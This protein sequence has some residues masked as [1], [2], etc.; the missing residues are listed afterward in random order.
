MKAAFL[1]FLIGLGAARAW[2]GP[3]FQTDDPEP[4]DYQHYEFYTFASSDGTPLET[5][6]T[7]PATEFNWGALPNI[8][9]HV[10]VPA[11]TIMPSDEP[12]EFG[13]GDIETG[14]KYRFVQETKHRPMI[15]TFTMF[16][17]PSGNADRGL[18]VGKLW[19]K[20]P[21][22]IQKSFGPWTTYGG[23]GETLIH[24]V[25]GY[26]NFPFA[27]WLIQRDLGKKWTLG[28]EAFYH[29][30]EGDATPQ[31]RSST[32]V[33]FGGYY[34]F[35]DPGFQLLFA[36]GHNVAGQTENYAYFGL[37]WTWGKEKSGSNQSAFAS[38]GF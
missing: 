27:G 18:G 15:G 35:R 29:G 32:L 6:L 8:H 14:I 17:V 19:F 37:Y 10:I 9:L 2:A 31:T 34:K 30:P 23:G 21:I 11:L 26:R 3:P 36:Y 12:R 22:W 20:L 24:G 25:P 7:G 28:T 16:E 4:I 13:L 5:D 1:C 33:D 38:R